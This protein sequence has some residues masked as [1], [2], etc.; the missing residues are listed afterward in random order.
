MM[1]DF[2]ERIEVDAVGSGTSVLLR[3]ARGERATPS[4]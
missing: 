1:L 3:F 4:R 2:A